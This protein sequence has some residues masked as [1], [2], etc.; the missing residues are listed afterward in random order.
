MN[1]TGKNSVI[2]NSP[3]RSNTIQIDKSFLQNYS[4]TTVIYIIGF[5]IFAFACVYLY[6]YYKSFKAKLQ[7]TQAQLIPECPDY[8]ETIGD[9]KCKNVNFLGSCANS[10]N[11]N[12]VDFSGEIFT[13]SNTGDYTKCKWA[14]ACSMPWSGIE[15]VC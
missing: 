5:L 7:A 6:N 1:T 3:V 8:W 9:K 4:T 13:N 10:S 12:I 11:N 2:K 15:R 14:K